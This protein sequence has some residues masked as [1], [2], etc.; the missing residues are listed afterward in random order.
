MKKI[1][2][3]CILLVVLLGINFIS[4][5]DDFPVL[6]GPYL[7]QKPPGI[8]PEIFGKGFVSTNHS[9]NGLCASRDGKELYFTVNRMRPYVMVWIRHKESGWTK[10]E[11]MPFSGNYPE[12]DFNI[13]PDGKRIYYTSYR[14]LSGKGDPE[15]NNNIWVVTREIVYIVNEVI[16][17]PASFTPKTIFP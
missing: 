6:K 14:P 3:I 8:I 10:P 2:T 4:A 12:W 5:K 1:M 17:V 16:H 15:D 7:G 13:S 11:T 9:E